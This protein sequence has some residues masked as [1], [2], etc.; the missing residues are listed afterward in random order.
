MSPAELSPETCHAPWQCGE[1]KSVL[2]PSGI[3]DEPGTGGPQAVDAIDSV[4]IV[5][6]CPK[7]VMI[8][9]RRGRFRHRMCLGRLVAS[10]LGLTSPPAPFRVGNAPT[11]SFF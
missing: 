2:Q 3:D 7:M 8:G 6:A 11:D 9:P 1:G 5:I 10:R 4:E